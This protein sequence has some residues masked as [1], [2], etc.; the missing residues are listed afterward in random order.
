MT[1]ACTTTTTVITSAAA[2]GPKR[3]T[4]RSAPRKCPLVPAAMGKLSIC[5]AKMKAAVTPRRGT[6]RSPKSA[7][8]LLAAYAT[9]PAET[10]PVA[11]AVG[12]SMKPSGICMRSGP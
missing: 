7:A 5:A 1:S 8:V 10:A 9:T 11:R 4:A 12:A 6:V 2:Q 3:A